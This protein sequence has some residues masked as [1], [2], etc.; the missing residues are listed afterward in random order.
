M[1]MG[2]K[3]RQRGRKK[4]EKNVL[5]L[6]YFLLFPPHSS[7][8]RERRGRDEGRGKARESDAFSLFLSFSSFCFRTSVAVEGGEEKREEGKKCIQ[9]NFLIFH[10]N[11]FS[12]SPCLFFPPRSL[13]EGEGGVQ[14]A[15]CGGCCGRRRCRCELGGE[16][17]GDG[18]VGGFF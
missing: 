9:K 16:A 5:L 17:V 14:D 4:K 7:G 3:N 10:G 11:A 18:V 15:R 13:D 6:F 12:R 1:E 2:E 8:N